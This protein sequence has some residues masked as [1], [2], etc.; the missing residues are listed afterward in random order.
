MLLQ[1]QQP[2]AALAGAASDV[3]LALTPVLAVAAGPIA[4]AGRA[5]ARLVFRPEPDAVD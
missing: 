3:F 4:P 2:V 1:A 5:A